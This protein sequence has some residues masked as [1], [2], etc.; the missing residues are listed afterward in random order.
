[1]RNKNIQSE[2]IE[3]IKKKLQM[4][5]DYDNQIAA[6]KAEYNHEQVFHQF[7]YVRLSWHHTLLQ[8]QCLKGQKEP[9]RNIFPSDFTLTI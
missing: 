5:E 3:D 8:K 1:M 7:L 2:S 6:V 9:D 4:I